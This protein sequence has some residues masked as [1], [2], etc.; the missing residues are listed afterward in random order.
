M[1]KLTL[2]IHSEIRVLASRHSD[3]AGTFSL[4]N[5]YEGREQL[6]IKVWQRD[7]KLAQVFGTGAQRGFMNW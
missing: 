1:H 6:A 7:K 2:Q 4:G 5:S 3:V